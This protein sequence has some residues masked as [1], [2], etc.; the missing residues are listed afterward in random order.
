MSEYSN[1]LYGEKTTALKHIVISRMNNLLEYSNL[2]HGEKTIVSKHIVIFG[3]NNLFVRH[4]IK[5]SAKI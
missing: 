2:L 5:S 4:L 1:L 3:M